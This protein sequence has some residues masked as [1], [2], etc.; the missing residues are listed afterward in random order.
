[1]LFEGLVYAIL[2]M[3]SPTTRV[4]ADEAFGKEGPQ[5]S[6]T[7]ELSHCRAKM[8]HVAQSWLDCD[9]GLQAKVLNL[10]VPFLLS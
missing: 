5:V 9:L 10:V 4:K 2:S 3:G 8:E 7:L 1:M 6:C